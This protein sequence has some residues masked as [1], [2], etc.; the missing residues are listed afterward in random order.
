MSNLNLLARLM[1]YLK[2]ILSISNPKFLYIY[3]YIPDLNSYFLFLFSFFFLQRSLF[4]R[5][6]GHLKWWLFT[7]SVIDSSWFSSFKARP[8]FRRTHFI[9]SV[10]RRK[11]EEKKKKERGKEIRK[12]GSKER[13]K[14]SRRSL[15]TKSSWSIDRSCEKRSP[16]HRRRSLVWYRVCHIHIHTCRIL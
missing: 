11:L 8:S 14:M 16:D 13:R 2:C 12:E 1:G 6:I 9:H 10:A 4:A 3:I 7:V 5:L 15:V